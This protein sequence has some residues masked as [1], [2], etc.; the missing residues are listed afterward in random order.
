MQVVLHNS[1]VSVQHPGP[2]ATVFALPVAV[3]LEG[4]EAEDDGLVVEAEDVEGRLRLGEGRPAGV[5]DAVEPLISICL[6]TDL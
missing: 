4:G 6:I 3:G 1:V 5:S 2:P